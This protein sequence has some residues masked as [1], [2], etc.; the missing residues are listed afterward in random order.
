MDDYQ[1]WAN[2][3]RNLINREVDFHFNEREI[4]RSYFGYNI[5]K[6]INGK[7]DDFERPVLVYKK[8]NKDLFI[9]IPLTTKF[10]REYYKFFVGNINNDGNFALWEQ[11]KI[12]SSKRLIYRIGFAD[13]KFF[14]QLKSVIR[15]FIT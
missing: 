1:K 5:G 11:V 6:E 3:C 13:K 9:G 14:K 2:V 10:K 7:H 15:D 8:I 12:M 4:W